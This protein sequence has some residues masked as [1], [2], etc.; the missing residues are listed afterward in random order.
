MTSSQNAIEHAHANHA[1]Y[2]AGFLEL[3]RIPSVSTDPAYK[4]DL[5]RCADW[6]VNEMVRIGFNNCRKISTTGHPV[7][8]GD[9]LEAGADKPTVLIYAHYDVQPVDPLNLWVS[10]PFEPTFRDGKLYARGTVDDKS[11]VFIN[12]KALESIFAVDGKLPVNVKLFFEG[13]EESGS[14]NMHPFVAANK[15]LLKADH[16][17]LCDGGFDKDQ[18]AIIYSG[19]GIVSMEVTITGPDHDLHS[20]VYGGV[21]HNPLHVVGKIVSSFHDDT[22]RIQIPGFYDTVQK[23]GSDEL[24]NLQRV[25][26]LTSEQYLARSGAKHYWAESLASI[27]ERATALPTLEVN[28]IWGGYQGPGTKTVIPSKAGFKVTMR[29]VSDQDPVVITAM[30]RDYV[31]GFASNTAEIEVNTLAQGY[32]FRGLFEGAGVEAVQQALEATIGKRAIMERSG[33]SIPIAGM[34]QRE[35]GVP[36]THLGLGAGDNIHSPNEYVRVD[37]F[38]LSMDAAIRFYYNLAEIN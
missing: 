22:G 17:I 24:A 6:I 23:L 31:L 28:G 7:V 36:M 11:G 30:F 12:L 8:Y 37:D 16:L 21:V 29:L 35:L 20:G 3:L 5:E 38:Y 25:W 19:R 1:P 26:S 14:P 32:P 34:F 15:D 13:E 10:P 27:P 18:P 2:M 33:G 9:W 4:A